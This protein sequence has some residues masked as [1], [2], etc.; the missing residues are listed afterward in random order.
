MTDVVL[1]KDIIRQL[2]CQQRKTD[3]GAGPDDREQEGGPDGDGADR[4][5]GQPEQ[6]LDM[7][8]DG[9]DAS[10]EAADDGPDPRNDEPEAHV[11][12]DIQ[13]AADPNLVI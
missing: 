1:A 10:A 7:G 3:D 2:Q 5:A 13:A 6:P 8:P 12:G 11:Q 4:E 9:A